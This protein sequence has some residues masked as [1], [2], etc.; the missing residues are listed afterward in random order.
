MALALSGKK[1]DIQLFSIGSK[2]TVKSIWKKVECPL[3]SLLMVWR[4][5]YSCNVIIIG[6]EV[7]KVGHLA[8]GRGEKKGDI[9]LFSIGSKRTVKPIWKKVECPLFSPGNE[10]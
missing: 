8:G 3:F 4:E 1:R 9:Q 10:D 7:K 5:A 6:R 2:R